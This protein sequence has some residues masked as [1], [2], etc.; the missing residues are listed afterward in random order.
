[1][2]EDNEPTTARTVIR[3]LDTLGGEDANFV[4]TKSATLGRLRAAGFA[5]PDGF[6]VTSVALSDLDQPSVRSTVAAALEVLG[7]GAVAVRSSAAAEDLADAS[8]AGQYDSVLGVDGLGDV[9]AAI[10]EV[11]RSAE[12]ERVARYRAGKDAEGASP[13]VAVLVQRMVPAEVAGVAFTADP[14]TGDRDVVV[15]SAVRGLG[16]RLVSG[17]A[18]ADEWIVRAGSASR[19]RVAEDVIDATLAEDVAAL[20]RR[21]EAHEGRPQDIE[22]AAADGRIHLIQARAMTALPEPVS[23]QSPSPGAWSRDFRLGEWLGDPVTPLF[24][25]WLLTAIEEHMHHDYGDLLG[26]E[27]PQ[28]A[29]VLV[30]GWYFYG[31]NFM[32]TRPAALLAMMV[33]HILP[34]LLTRPRRTAIAFPPL[35]RFGVGLYEREWRNEVRP[36]YRRLVSQATDA[37]DLATP[38][39]LVELIDELAEA[40]GH[41]FTSATMV[42]GYASKAQIPLAR[43]YS[44][45]LAPRIGGSHLDLLA[46]LGDQPPAPA[47]HAVRTL[48]WAEPT[49]VETDATQDPARTK[50]RHAEARTRRSHAE[51]KAAEA[52]G[53][54]PK[55]LQRFERLLSEAQRYAIIREDL[56][57]EFTL[58]WPIL[59]RAVFRLGATLLDRGTIESIDDVLFLR[60]DELLGALGGSSTSLSSV[61]AERRH[62]WERQRRLVPPLRLGT[63][64]PMMK[65]F[66]ESAEQAVKGTDPT[67]I[68]DIV[69]IPASGGRASGPARV[70]HSLA[71][72]DRVQPGDVLVAPM[73]APAWTPL[74][75]RVAAIVTDTGGVAAHAS[76]VAREYGLPAVVGTADATRRLRDGEIVEVDGSAG[77]VRRLG[78]SATSSRV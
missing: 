76:I 49:L 44:A 74:F 5:V 70:V 72:F 30:N 73:T 7:A 17:E 9:L 29:H 24:E 42:A 56:V 16:D 20:A 31:L 41:Y 50:A 23:W 75:D 13:Q 69:G 62:L 8:F 57:A 10:G 4:G 2:I 28:P 64:P 61:T 1:M 22:W 21:V 78:S 58:P 48:D 27:Q 18:G 53:A 11:L 67:S 19:R 37:V 39:Q 68:D 25:S 32:P 47:P 60:H 38:A 12:S 63:M 40:A 36:R 54:D 3:W 51:A 66:T 46:G 55:L 43:F 77:V 65:R 14:I 52:L 71:D 34:R 15:V 6:V 45:H 26:V 59:R 35:A 33:R